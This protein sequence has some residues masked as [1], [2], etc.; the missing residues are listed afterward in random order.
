[1]KKTFRS[2]ML[3]ALT[4]FVLFSAV[5]CNFLSGIS[6]TEQTGESASTPQESTPFGTTPEPTP[7]ETT[8][9]A[10]TPESTTPEVTTP[11]ITTPEITT[12]EITTPEVTTPENT[13]PPEDDPGED[14][15][16]I[17]LEGYVYRAYVRS[18]YVGNNPIEDGNPNFQCEDFWYDYATGG[19]PENALSYAVYLRNQMIEKEYNVKIR[20]TPQRGNMADEMELFYL[21]GEYFDLSIILAKSGAQVATMGL[22]QDLNSL[23][24]LSLQESA[25]DKNSVRELSIG[26]KLYFVSGDMNISTLDCLTPTVVNMEL[27]EAFAEGIVE[28][29]GGDLAFTN[30]YN[31]VLEGKW[32]I[33]NML[34]IAALASVDCDTSDG[35][36]GSSVD[37]LVGYYQYAT[38]TL[39]YFYGAG[40]R[41][42][43]IN[44]EGV[45]EFVIQNEQ[46]QELFNYLF[47]NMNRNNRDIQYP[48]GWSA[49]RK[50]NFITNRNTL[51][52]EM[53]LW[54]LRKDLYFNA[55]FE[56]GILPTPTYNEGDDYHSVV[57]FSNLAHLW[58]IPTY[59]KD[60]LIAQLMM[61]TFV[62]LSD[63]AVTD[64][65]MDAYY[66]RTLS[67]A[68][69]L[70]PNARYAMNIIKNSTVYDIGLLYNW[71]G[72][73]EELEK[74]GER[75]YNN[76][77]SLIYMMPENAIPDLEATIERFI[78]PGLS[79]N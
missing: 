41:L 47:D 34:E 57:H 15:P 10:T 51:F 27:Y 78:N 50:A 61:E 42:T 73:V 59:C 40:G 16:M 56:Y 26:G 29:F 14:P 31:L 64:S 18:N 39:Y 22:L 60:S 46:H 19:E 45:P 79:E 76:Y 65:T 25:Y 24:L 35:A 3:I 9:E 55:D 53:S 2:A 74:L 4:V 43:E 12:P 23:P 62:A 48:Y 38:S 6:T 44:D 69:A 54:D 11:E 8:P 66:T 63:I 58:A 70:N 1:M 52:T 5:A 68:V 72:F 49:A 77:G 37:D 67:F 33:A 20:Q 30:V 75:I 71:G 28:H 17:D 32:T 13:T 7:E 21:N 36:L